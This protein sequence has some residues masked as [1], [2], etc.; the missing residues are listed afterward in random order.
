MGTFDLRGSA[1]HPALQ[2]VD[3]FLWMLQRDLKTEEGN[4]VFEK[5]ANY[6]EDFVISPAMSNRIVQA[7]V[8]QLNSTPLSKAQIKAG[9]KLSKKV[10]A[11]RQ[12]RLKSS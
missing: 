1:N 6:F 3:V 12:K 7:R 4:K 8:H 11:N 10:E 2:A 5:L 9:K